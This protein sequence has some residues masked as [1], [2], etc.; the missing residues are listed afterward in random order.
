MKQLKA[1]KGGRET[2]PRGTSSFPCAGYY[3]NIED[4]ITGDIPWHWHE[5]IEFFVVL[6][7]SC[8]ITSGSRNSIY[9]LEENDGAFINS[10]ILHTI[11]IIGNIGCQLISFVFS[12]CLLSS[13]EKDKITA[14]YITPYI[15]SRAL[16]VIPFYHK[17]EVDRQLI[18]GINNAFIAFVEKAYGYELHVRNALSLLWT[19][20]ITE[21]QALT[22]E[23]Y[24]SSVPKEEVRVRAMIDFIEKNY[25]KL[26]TPKEI[27]S[28]ISV[29]ER[30]CFRC[31]SQVLDETPI[32]YLTQY[33]IQVGMDLLLHSNQTIT[34][35]SSSCGFNSA[36]YFTK[37]FHT[38]TG[39]S[40]REYRKLQNQYPKDTHPIFS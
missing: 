14:K 11:E 23:L 2:L 29:S 36:S 19:Q 30:E 26:I 20:I 9:F 28:A 35:I 3:T 31:F 18:Y 13:G 24:N 22:K 40:P 37:I 32:G 1:T 15:Q 16:E 7:G 38:K 25:E 17:N 12:P 6:G 10:D 4:H 21:N 34:E 33:R 27:A 8:K 39:Y 5:E